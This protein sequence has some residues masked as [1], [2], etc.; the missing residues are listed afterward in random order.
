MRLRCANSISTFF[1]CR[2]GFILLSLCVLT[3]SDA[4]SLAED[5]SGRYLAAALV[6]AGH[7]HAD[8]VT[9]P[10]AKH[11]DS[12]GRTVVLLDI[13]NIELLTSSHENVDVVISSFISTTGRDVIVPLL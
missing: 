7:R 6:E 2:P 5:G 12:V 8:L 10:V 3:V 4:R 9:R 13:P 11:S 1:R